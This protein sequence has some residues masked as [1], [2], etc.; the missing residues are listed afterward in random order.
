MSYDWPGNV[1][2][3]RNVVERAIILS[4]GQNEIRLEHLAIYGGNRQSSDLGT[5]L[6]FE[7]EPTLDQV[8]KQYLHCLLEKYSG[9]RGKVA[10]VMGISERNIYRLIQKY[11]LG[12]KTEKEAL[13]N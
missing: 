10:S 3:L 4:R 9:H 1:R 7:K 5:Q 12:K 2:E 13:S 6:Q 11:G 8:E